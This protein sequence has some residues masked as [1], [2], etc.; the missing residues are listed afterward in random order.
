MKFII[1][2]A[3]S[4]VVG[5]VIGVLVCYAAA[6]FWHRRARDLKKELQQKLQKAPNKKMGVLDKVLLYE[7]TFLTLYVIMDM[8]VFWHVGSEPSTL[9][10]CVF[11]FWGCENGVMGW[12]QT[13]KVKVNGQSTAGNTGPDPE[14]QEPPDV[15]C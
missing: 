13:N 15:G 11:A 1:I 9:T 2:A 8:I 6:A 7:I 5:A 3:V 12:I 10:S 4:W 14:R